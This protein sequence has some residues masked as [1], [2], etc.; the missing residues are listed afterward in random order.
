MLLPQ[1]IA[2]GIAG[3]EVTLAFRR[4]KT[5][6]VRAGQRFRS[7]VGVILIE[8]IEAVSAVSLAE[9]RAAGFAT[10]DDALAPLRGD[11]SDP[12]FRIALRWDGVDERIELAAS[13]DLD[14][15]ERMNLTR[16]LGRLDARSARGPWTRQVLHLIAER[17]GV[18]AGDLAESLGYE[19]DAFKLNVRKLKN[20]GLTTSL[21]VGYEISE[22]G[23]SYL[24]GD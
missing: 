22:R 15:E 7:S 16:S 11:A 9:A 12:L 2:E 3:G 21:D 14:P 6:R 20:L 5:A 19:R 23:R 13:S 8:S 1:R 4:W 18:R 24:A 17:P 10:V